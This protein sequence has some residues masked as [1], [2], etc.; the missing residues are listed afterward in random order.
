MIKDFEEKDSRQLIELW[1][2][3]F[4]DERQYIESFFKAF[5]ATM[6]VCVAYFDGKIVSAIYC[7]PANVVYGKNAEK[8][9]YLYAVSTLPEY[10][11]KGYA[12][13][14]LEELKKEEDGIQC[15]IL[16]PSSEVNRFFYKKLG[17]IDGPYCKRFDFEYNNQPCGVTLEERKDEN[18]FE[19]REKRLKEVP[20]I[21]WGEEHIKFATDGNVFFAVADG[22]TVGYFHYEKD[23]NEILL[24]EVCV[25][26]KYLDDT[27]NE[28]CKKFDVK[29]LKVYS[30]YDEKCC[31]EY[32]SMIYCKFDRIKK[33]LLKKQ[34]YLGLNLE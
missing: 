18:I 13:A 25:D 28:A 2:I 1:E 9:W 19:I 33:D 7:L 24:D 17:F 5:R 22:K 11:K 26:K 27:L 6:K 31:K 23:G 15:L 8:A 10:R 14:L 16:T 32:K 21:S 34:L 20:H 12:S 30:Y 3:C 4:G 29:K